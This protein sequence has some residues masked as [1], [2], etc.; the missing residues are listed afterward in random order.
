MIPTWL[1]YK[2][3]TK[4]TAPFVFA[5]CKKQSGFV[6]IPIY[7]LAVVP[8]GYR[9]IFFTLS[10]LVFAYP[11]SGDASDVAQASPYVS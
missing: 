2:A 5:E 10:V 9:L 6:V 3:A 8:V 4:W 1:Y 11:P 7:T